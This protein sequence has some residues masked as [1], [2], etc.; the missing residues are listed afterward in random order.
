MRKFLENVKMMD[1]GKVLVLFI[2][3]GVMEG[4]GKEVCPKMCTCDVF[5]GYRRADCR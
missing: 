2:A 1:L 4:G 5:E 3:W